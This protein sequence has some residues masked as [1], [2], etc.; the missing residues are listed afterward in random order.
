MET[1]E[2]Q[3]ELWEAQWEADCWDKAAQ[4]GPQLPAA[5]AMEKLG[6][7]VLYVLY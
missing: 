5:Q 7:E 4:L 1:R 6:L 2:L 3:A